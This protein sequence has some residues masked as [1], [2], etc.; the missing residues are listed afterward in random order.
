MAGP[1]HPLPPLAPARDGGIMAR[2]R[3]IQHGDLPSCFAHA[4]TEFIVF[5][6]DQVSTHAI[7]L[8]EDPGSQQKTAAAGV[9]LA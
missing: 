7:H 3:R 1:A 8:A 4:Q 6:G 2:H 9:H 5:S